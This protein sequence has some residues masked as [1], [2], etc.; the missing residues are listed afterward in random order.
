MLQIIKSQCKLLTHSV[1]RFCLLTWFFF[2]LH[3][4]KCST[5]FFFQL[6][7]E[8]NNTQNNHNSQ[9]T[10][11]SNLVDGEK[12]YVTI[13]WNGQFK[14]LG[15]QLVVVTSYY[16]RKYTAKNTIHQYQC[17]VCGLWRRIHCISPIH[18]YNMHVCL[19]HIYCCFEYMD[20]WANGKKEQASLTNEFQTT[21]QFI[22]QLWYL[23][24][25]ILHIF[26]AHFHES[27]S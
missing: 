3:L 24:V 26:R 21:T 13:Q 1:Q 12:S 10:F 22:K 18:M 16:T 6:N 9:W 17:T 5:N 19:A 8:K 11:A 7:D 14:K 23:F 2:F 25:L 27:K 20:N 15:F 4:T